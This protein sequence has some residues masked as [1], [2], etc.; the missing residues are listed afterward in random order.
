V[1]K[2]SKTKVDLRKD[3]MTRMDSMSKVD[4]V[5]PF[6]KLRSNQSLKALEGMLS[7]QQ[8]TATAKPGQ[9]FL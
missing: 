4:G 7:I 2:E 8:A 1:T 6:V 3:R 9:T 5:V